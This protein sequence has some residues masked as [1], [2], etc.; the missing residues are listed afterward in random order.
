M[1]SNR[2]ERVMNAS[3]DLGKELE[4]KCPLCDGEGYL[5]NTK[6]S[7][8]NGV[9]FILTDRGEAML[10]FLARHLKMTAQ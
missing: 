6:C 2:K 8:C 3:I 9:G 10:N 1:R 5:G 4:S 7:E